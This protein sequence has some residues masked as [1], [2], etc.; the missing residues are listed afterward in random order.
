MFYEL[1]M[2]S[3][4]L[5]VLRISLPWAAYCDTEILRVYSY[6]N[7]TAYLWPHAVHCF[8]AIELNNL[9]IHMVYGRADFGCF[10]QHKSTA[11]AQ[12]VIPI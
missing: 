7:A 1:F 10:R 5:V 11:C 3:V 6:M 2:H 12:D 8:H 9:Q 4:Y